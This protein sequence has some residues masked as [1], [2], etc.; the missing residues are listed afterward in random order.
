MR[1]LMILLPFCLFIGCAPSGSKNHCP[2]ECPE[3]MTPF[4]GTVRYIE[5]E[6]GFYAVH[7]EASGKL[8]GNIPEE[9]RKDGLEVKGCFADDSEAPISFRMYGRKV[10]FG[11]ISKAE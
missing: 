1:Y 9:L 4:V 5:L 10:V 2:D 6:G 3:G 8:T 11:C 7:T